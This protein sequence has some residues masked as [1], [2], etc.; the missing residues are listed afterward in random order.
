MTKQSLILEVN[1]TRLTTVEESQVSL[2]AAL[3]IPVQNWTLIVIFLV[4]LTYTHFA[5]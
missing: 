4:Q 5:V 2:L 1:G 3:N